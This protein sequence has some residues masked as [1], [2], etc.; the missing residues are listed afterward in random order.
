MARR[1]SD[2]KNFLLPQEA[3]CSASI[4]PEGTGLHPRSTTYIGSDL[5]QQ[6][7]SKT[8]KIFLSRNQR[9]IG[10]P[11]EHWELAQNRHIDLLWLP[12]P[13]GM[14]LSPAEWTNRHF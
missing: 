6:N 13:S 2:F 7:I 14:N 9:I 12:Y 4:V 5:L 1:H 3:V 8:P 10:E 11:G